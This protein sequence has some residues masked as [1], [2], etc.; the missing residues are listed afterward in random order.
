MVPSVPHSSTAARIEEESS[1]SHP[2]GTTIHVLG[3]AETT[4]GIDVLV[5]AVYVV[6]R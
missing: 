3:G 4:V 1:M 6:V 5:A 2:C